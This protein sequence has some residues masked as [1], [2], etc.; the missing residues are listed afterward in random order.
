[1]KK[2]LFTGGGHSEIPL[3][4]AARKLG[5]YV[6][7]T[8]NNRD[9]LG[10]KL[11]DEYIPGDFSNQEFVLHLAQEKNVVGIVAGCNDF[12][13]LSAAYAAE[14]LGLPG[15]DTYDTAKTIHTKDSFRKVQNQLGIK[16]PKAVTCC[17]LEDCK[18]A[19]QYFSFPLLV[20][21]VDL[22]GGKGVVK[23][24]N[25]AEVYAAFANAI[26]LTRKKY[27]IL[28]TFIEGSSHGISALLK[29]KKVVCHME[30]D[31]QYGLNK[32]LV[33]GACSPSSVPERAIHNLIIDI[34][35]IAEYLDLCD[36][37]FHCQ[38]ILDDAGDAIMIDPCRRAPG[39]LYV[40]LS[41]YATDVDYPKEIVKGELGLGI[42]DNYQIS[43]HIVARECIMTE[44]TGIV[45]GVY[46]AP[47]LQKYIV[48][49]LILSEIGEIVTNPL[50]YKGG[51][52]VAI[53]SDY[54]EMMHDVHEF[55]KLAYLEMH[56]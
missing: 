6:I 26:Q 7:T 13:Y 27:I 52:L 15:H 45:D 21:P 8:G 18:E 42:E 3:I 47:E 48:H 1:M 17:R 22:T 56:D 53:Y 36:G 20:K 31:E 49:S 16:S 4:E 46:V 5:Y 28:E 23:C 39:D 44:K 11:A 51:I 54:E 33:Q 32:Y 14:K 34:E 29:N 55:H 2:I 37:L 43:K 38:F 12:A 41:K 9:G 35:K 25:E 40:L 24:Q 50:V 30:D 10:H 19:L